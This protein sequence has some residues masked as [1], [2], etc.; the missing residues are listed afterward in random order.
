MKFLTIFFLLIFPITLLAFNLDSL[1][2]RPIHETHRIIDQIKIDGILSENDWQR[3]GITE[4]TQRE[5]I[6]GAKPSQSSEVWI[7][8]DDEAIYVGA[9]LSDDHPDSIVSRIGRRDAELNSDWFA[10]A[11]DSY[12]DR[13]T[14]FF[15]GVY[16]S[17]S[18]LDGILYNDS[19]DDK[20][21]DGV[22]DAATTID[23]KGWTAEFRI[24]YSQLRFTEQ[25]EYIW[26]VNIARAIERT[27]EELWYV[28]IPKKESGFVSHFADLTGIKNI[29]PPARIEI[30]PYVVSSLKLTNQFEKGD[31]FND[32]K[33]FLGNAGADIKIGLGS[34]LTLNATINPDF[35]Q[36]EVDPAVVN[37]SQFET[38]FDEKR[39]FFVEGSNYFNFGYGGANNNY[40]FNWGS[41]DFFYSRRIGRQPRGDV[42]HDGFQDFPD[43]T[44]IL[45]AAKLTGKIV[46]GWSL[47]T[48]SALT[49]REYAKIDDGTGNNFEDVV[50]P[51]T[52]YNIIRSQREFN[53][54]RQAL[55]MMGTA[56]F[57]D[58][59]KPYL[60]DQYNQRS[61]VVGLDGWTNLD[62]DREYVAAGWLASSLVEGSTQRMIDLQRSYLHYFQ[63]PDQNY[64]T[65]DSSKTSLSGYAGRLALNKEKGNVIFNTAFGFITPGFEVNDLGFQSRANT[66]NGHIVLGYRWLE[67]DGIFRSKNFQIATFR[68]FDFDGNKFGEGYF[69]FWN[70]HLMN[71]WNFGGQFSLTN[72]TYDLFSTR[73]G[74]MMKNTRSYN[75]GL[76]GSTDSRNPIIYE[77]E[78]GASRSESGGSYIEIEPG[79]EWKPTPGINFRF[80]PEFSRG[81]TTAQWIPDSNPV[82]DSNAIHTYG[83]RYLFSRLDQHEI[84][85]SIRVDWTFTPKL[86]LQIYL[87]PLISVGKYYD[88]KELAKA[89]TFTF[90][91]YGGNGS[92]ISYV[93]STDSYTVD[94]DGTGERNFN[95]SNPNFN[96]KYI[97]FNVV[98]RWEFLPGSTAFLVW[99]RSGDHSGNA[100]DF[101]L[102][103]DFGNLVKAPN[104]EDVFLLKIAYWW[105]P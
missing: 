55:G 78:L 81:L 90:N 9:R 10:I 53:Q 103:R 82:I 6:E 19:W 5:P 95:F 22:W 52:S 72:P 73:G 50:E 36:V 62:S 15:F 77:L 32:G 31:P 66:F 2:S 25:N 60:V 44:T 89:G 30:L 88:F 29:H 7:A 58:L 14:G 41:P 79:I 105:H 102:G 23:D 61:Y 28:M 71:Y 46:E 12:H 59:N 101:K 100:G 51:L 86:S 34:N 97:R 70:A 20:S 17:G 76:F 16:P 4:F 8:Y 92:T 67:P 96:D 38:F 64:V 1:D 21:W 75:A 45:G 48:V 93:D 104:H 85:A 35:G 24:P 80:S 27:K 13:R 74:P 37:L 69:L 3:T 54:G 11:F 57:R 47:A 18:I 39:P 43:A 56:V 33:N 91:R 84:S 63:R 26:G 65:V 40:G 42:Q 99:T 98:L 83:K 68:N 87:Q 49:Q 94:P